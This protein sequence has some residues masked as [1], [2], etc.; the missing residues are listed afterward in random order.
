MSVNKDLKSR[1]EF[2]PDVYIDLGEWAENNSGIQIVHFG[3]WLID[4]YGTSEAREVIGQDAFGQFYGAMEL[5]IGGGDGG[6]YWSEPMP[7]LDSAKKVASERITD[8]ILEPIE[9]ETTPD[10]PR[11]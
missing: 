8:W 3:E 2:D 4:G 9:D 6:L 11:C 5:S 7:S 1:V 10:R